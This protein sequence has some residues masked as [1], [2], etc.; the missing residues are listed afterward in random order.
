MNP[1]RRIYH[2]WNRRKVI[3]NSEIQVYAS[4][5]TTLPLEHCNA[6]QLRAAARFDRRKAA[7]HSRK[8]HKQHKVA[9]AAWYEIAAD[10][11]EALAGKLE[12][13][14]TVATLPYRK[15]KHEMEML[16]RISTGKAA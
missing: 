6:E 10:A 9:N 16:L 2:W 12:D 15:R 3:R 13:G 4:R 14:Q 1:F 5:K 7:L 11:L 8:P